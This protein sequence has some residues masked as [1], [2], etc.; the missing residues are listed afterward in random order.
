MKKHLINVTFKV[1]TDFE[2][3]KYYNYVGLVNETIENGKVVFY[4]I[5]LF[6]QLFGFDLP[7]HSIITLN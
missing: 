4:P 1:K 6:K 7:T 5:N 3:V 2:N